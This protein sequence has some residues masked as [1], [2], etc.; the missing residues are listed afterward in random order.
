MPPT[1]LPIFVDVVSLAEK[2][3][4]SYKNVKKGRLSNETTKLLNEVRTRI[5]P[6]GQQRNSADAIAA[7]KTAQNTEMWCEAAVAH[8]R[9]ADAVAQ[10]AAIVARETNGVYTASMLA[11]VAQLQN[12]TGELRNIRDQLKIANGIRT[13]GAAGP[14]GFA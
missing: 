8:R 9:A 14:H 4:A 1:P 6:D 13:Q 7:L 5:L 12:I 11:L 2:G 3:S 10:T